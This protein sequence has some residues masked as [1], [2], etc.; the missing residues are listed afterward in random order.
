MA[1]TTS[2]ENRRF[3]VFNATDGVPAAPDLVTLGEAQ[4][5]ILRFRSRYA[6]Q[7]YYLTAFGDR[8]PAER[9]ELR[10]IDMASEPPLAWEIGALGG[11][12]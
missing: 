7:G 9:V 8:I 11:S 12:A 2:D 5:F 10:I 4:R 3:M 6:A 1:S